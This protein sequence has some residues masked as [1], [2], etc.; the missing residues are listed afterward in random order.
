M[1]P[2]GCGQ[3]SERQ[4]SFLDIRMASS[5][6]EPLPAPPLNPLD[7]FS[8]HRRERECVSRESVCVLVSSERENVCERER[9]CV[10]ERECVSRVTGCGRCCPICPL[11]GLATLCSRA[12][13][14]SCSCCSRFRTRAPHSGLRRD[15]RVL[16]EPGRFCTEDPKV[17]CLMRSN[18]PMSLPDCLPY[19]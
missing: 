11:S 18:P 7:A 15:F 10:C 3:T 1:T 17:G 13:V 16:T 8:F 12:F 4:P 5:V 6:L 14:S 9:V 2:R 19:H